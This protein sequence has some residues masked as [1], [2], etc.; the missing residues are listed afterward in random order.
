MQ[1]F[2]DGL[3][4]GVLHDVQGYDMTTLAALINKT[5][6][7]EDS[8]NKMNDKKAKDNMKSRKRPFSLLD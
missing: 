5:K 7:M 4:P 8:R 3:D 1:E 2:K 6:T